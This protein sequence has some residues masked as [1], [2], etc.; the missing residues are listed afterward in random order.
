M[1]KK[2]SISSALRGVVSYL[3]LANRISSIEPR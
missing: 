3:N 1:L 2:L